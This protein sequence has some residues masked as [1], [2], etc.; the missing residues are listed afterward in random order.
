M[1]P[2]PGDVQ[3]IFGR[4]LEVES[5]PGRAAFLDEACGADA[6]LRAE[7]EGLLATLGRAGE[8]MRRPAAAAAGVTLGPEPVAEGPGAV[9]GRY[10]LL[11]QIGEG[12]FGVVFM[13]EQREPVRR[14]VAL[15]IIKPGMDTRQVIARFEAERQAL[16]LMDHP[17]IARVL[18]ADA[19]ASGR[20]YFVMELVRGVLITEFCDKN[21]LPPEGRL[22]LF[23]D[24]CH[25]VQHA[26]HKGV[27]HRDL[28]PSNILITL[29]D[30]VPV[31]KV[32]DFGVAKATAQR[33]TERTLFTSYGQ[34][35]G[36]PAYMS[37]E[38]AEMSGLDIDTRSDVY[39]L[40][41]LLYELLTGTTPLEGKRLREAGY[42]EMQRLI[43]DEEAPRPST[44]LSSLGET[45]TVL[46]GNR[47]L[48]VKRL[49]QLLA[50]DLD[51]VV[52]KAL[53]KDR[54]RRY[55][56]PGNFAED[57]ER[58]LRREPVLARPPSAAYQLRKFVQRNRAA[59]LA[60]AAVAAAL[61]VGL[62]VAVWQAVRATQAEGTAWA[63]L[64]ET[65]QARAAETRARDRTSEALQRLTDEV[66]EEI[67]GKQ[68]QISER[69]K[70]F[71]RHV[72]RLYEEFA[73][74][75]GDT[76]SARAVRAA[77]QL[78]VAVMRLH[79]GDLEKAEAGF[80]EVI[81]LWKQLATEFPDAPDNRLQ[82]AK[83]YGSLGNLLS[84]QK[85][86]PEAE[87]V[88]Q[89]RLDLLQ[90]LAADHPAEPFY[91]HDLARGLD[92]LGLLFARTN[93]PRQAED[94]HN[95]AVNLLQ[96]LVVQHPEVPRFRQQL[97]FSLNN[98][99]SV[100]M[101][102]N[103]QGEAEAPFQKALSLGRR[104]V[105]DYPDVPV[106]RQDLSW[107]LEA[108]GDLFTATGRSAQAMTHHLEALS[109]R[110][111]LAADFPAVLGYQGDL[112]R[113][114]RSIRKTLLVQ[115]HQFAKAKDAAGCRR[116]AEMLEK[117]N[118]SDAVSLYDA[119]CLRAVTASVLRAAGRSAEAD[120]EADRAT[121]WLKQ[122]VAAGYKD[123]AHV[124]TDRDLDAL[125]GREDFQRLEA[126]LKAGPVRR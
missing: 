48:D 63:A 72:E 68:V 40:G 25:A 100:L 23:I 50:G 119:A 86:F 16:A 8:F 124:G 88:Y 2:S 12:G 60:G 14:Q 17:N 113:S 87:A 49:V 82:L 51:W 91:R 33:L 1:P 53:S 26:H 44:R 108:L 37:P 27:I 70:T 104:L 58:Y 116:T 125:R 106:Y 105:L 75:L 69:E 103:R 99:G 28:K 7:V 43:R 126:G 120:T 115:L 11:E 114:R 57:V 96:D 94:R 92:N 101:D 38:Q 78:R 36:T 89:Q 109:L 20:P 97:T 13:A 122:A 41:V 47:G 5:A 35:I 67:L 81:P 55:A 62:A 9:V 73:H 32:I 21:H 24:V 61:L 112:E 79:L 71:L 34:M 59:V 29:H 74:E 110:S 76:A 30:G 121:A 10:K 15:K 90:Q 19:T 31:V 65:V 42:S 64:E 22:R 107:R 111:R 18:D 123:A 83:A 56:T 4:A 77:A 98:L 118:W 54:N 66:V 52:L 45:A 93:R 6:A 46:A 80:R 3:S 95:A 84:D 102:T 39:S 117:L 85:R